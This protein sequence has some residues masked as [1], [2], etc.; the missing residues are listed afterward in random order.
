MRLIRA[1]VEREGYADM[2]DLADRF[3]RLAQLRNDLAHS[4][5]GLANLPAYGDLWR[6]YGG[7]TREPDVL[8]GVLTIDDFRVEVER[9]IDVRERMTMLAYR[10]GYLQLVTVGGGQSDLP[11]RGPGT[12]RVI[13]DD[14]GAEVA[15]DA[16]DASL[17]TQ[18]EGGS[19][20]RCRIRADRRWRGV[21]VCHVHD[22]DGRNVAARPEFREQFVARLRHSP[23]YVDESQ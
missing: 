10:V 17:P 16:D 5:L 7:R 23:R 3:D 12:R 22:P 2:A 21:P 4:T 13:R 8:Q 18:Y 19:G 14:S 1:A 11:E 9:A 6:L 20:K 15:V